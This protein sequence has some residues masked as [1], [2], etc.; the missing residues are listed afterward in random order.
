[1]LQFLQQQGTAIIGDSN[2]KS[3]NDDKSTPSFTLR[4]P[5]YPSKLLYHIGL[6]VASHIVYVNKGNTN[7][8]MKE[9]TIQN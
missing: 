6:T 7:R 2:N 8:T 3:P 4:E 5:D 9:D 1:M